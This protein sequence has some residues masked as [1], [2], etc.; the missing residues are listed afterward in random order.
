MPEDKGNATVI[1]DKWDYEKKA[2]DILEKPPFVQLVRDPTPRNDKRGN[3]T[4]KSLLD[5]KEIS[6]ATYDNLRVSEK[7][8]CPPL[9]YGSAKMYKDGVPLRPMV[10]TI[11]SATY[12]IAKRM[13]KI[14][15]PYA[16]G[17][18][19]YITN[20]KDF[21]KKI[22]DVIIED[23]EVMVSFDIKSLFTYECRNRRSDQSY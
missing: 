10:S 18:D 19:N 20:T 11:G 4:L 17:A 9:F 7:G 2:A 23:D 1:I 6:Q 13:N 3:G 8:T 12:R 21:I 5:A 14:L 22:E 15:A 16:R